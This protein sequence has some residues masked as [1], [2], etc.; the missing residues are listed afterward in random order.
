MVNSPFRHY[1]AIESAAT[2]MSHSLEILAVGLGGVLAAAVV[3][4]V[5]WLVTRRSASRSAQ[6][7]VTTVVSELTSRVD[8]LAGDLQ[9]A[10]DRAESE[11]RRS[12]FLGELNASIDLDEV[13]ARVLDSTMALPGVD[14]A[15]VSL[16]P[17]DD[18]PR[19]VSASGMTLEQAERQ[20]F[21]SPPDIEAHAMSISYR[22]ADGGDG[23]IRSAL[24]LP[25]HGESEQIGYIAAY[26][27]ARE[28]NRDI[29]D[30]V[31]TDLE[32]VALRAGPALENALR[33]REARR[34]ADLD[35]LTGLH[36]RRY[37]HEILAREV[38]R[39]HRY[40]RRLALLLFDLDDFKAI[41]ERI[42][43]LAGDSVLAEA[44]TRLLTVV[45]GSDV[46]CRVG[47]DEFAV[48]LPE[49]GIGQ[50]DQLYR[51]IQGAVS[52]RPIGHVARLDLS[53]GVAELTPED[54]ANALFERADEALYR[55]KDAGKARAFPAIVPEP[56][57]P[58]ASAGA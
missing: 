1:S 15:I 31:S 44:A 57:T 29:G 45:R 17:D 5:A 22:Y 27:R 41:N 49:S 8:E 19:V 54:D 58:E 51:R 38:A 52:N 33:F 13:L 36:N 2:A 34:L 9:L 16:E 47:G 48:I 43:H 7:Q 42:G 20:V 56:G 28:R 18:Q 35:A 26:S 21:A 23:Q 55:A 50:A 39:A 6:A 46:P 4:I 37:F 30:D 24:V 11:G 10:L 25:L 14:A 53:A 32:E 40:D 12:R 3:G